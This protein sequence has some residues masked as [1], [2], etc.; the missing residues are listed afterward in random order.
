M[1]LRWD[2]WIYGLFSGFIGGGA[3]A[4]VSSGVAA[5]LAPDKFSPANDFKNFIVLAGTTFLANG[6]LNAFFFLKQSPLPP[7]DDDSKPRAFVNPN[8][9]EPKP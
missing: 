7:P 3:A 6:L 9:P 8:P 5:V 2:K 1:K 4:V